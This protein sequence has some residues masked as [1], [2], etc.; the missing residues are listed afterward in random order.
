MF[1]CKWYV[2]K[3]NSALLCIITMQRSG[4]RFQTM[5]LLQMFIIYGDKFVRLSVVQRLLQ[6]ESKLSGH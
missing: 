1:A 2:D 5:G 6:W 3:K 4:N